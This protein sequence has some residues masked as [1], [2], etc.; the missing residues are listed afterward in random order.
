MVDV[1]HEPNQFQSYAP[2]GIIR[3]GKVT[4]SG[5]QQIQA[6]TANQSEQQ[7][8]QNVLNVLKNYVSS[9]NVKDTTGGKQFYT[10]AKDG[11]MFLGN[12]IKEAKQ[13]A[14]NHEKQ[15]KIKPTKWGTTSGLPVQMVKNTDTLTS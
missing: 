3:G 12:T 1:L 15:L 2:N 5:Y 9:E 6:G 14:N 8:Y 7:K 10:H 13:N 4:P 11:T